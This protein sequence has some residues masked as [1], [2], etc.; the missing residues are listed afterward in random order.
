VLIDKPEE[1]PD[2]PKLAFS[3]FMTKVKTPNANRQLSRSMLLNEAIAPLNDSRFVPFKDISEW[4]G[5]YGSRISQPFVRTT[6][7]TDIPGTIKNK[8]L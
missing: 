3:R 4:N 6:R 1:E 8:S 5:K 2:D 7:N